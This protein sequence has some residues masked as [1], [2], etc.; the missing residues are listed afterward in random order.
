MKGQCVGEMPALQ[1]CTCFPHVVISNELNP[2]IWRW[3]YQ[4]AYKLGKF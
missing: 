1:A 3:D 4:S 2:K